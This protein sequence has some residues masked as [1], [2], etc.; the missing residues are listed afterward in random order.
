MLIPL[1]TLLSIFR[2]DAALRR[3]IN[4]YRIP[5]RGGIISLPTLTQRVAMD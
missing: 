3:V 1:P 5:N 2:A 4:L